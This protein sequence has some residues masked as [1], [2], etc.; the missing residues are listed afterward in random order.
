M[1]D[2]QAVDTMRAMPRTRRL[3]GAGGTTFADA[4]ASFP[5]CCPSR[6]SFLTGQYAHNHGVRDNGPPNGGIAALDQDHTLPVWLSNAGYRTGFVGKYLNGYGKGRNGGE[7]FIPPGWSDW[8][9]APGHG[10]KSPYDYALNENGTLVRYG[11]ERSDY[12]TDVFADLAVDYIARAA[13]DRP[14]FLWVAT[15]APHTDNGLPANAPRNPVPAERDRG[16]FSAVRLPMPASFN[17]A[18][19][20]DKPLFVRKQPP[21]NGR[22]RDEMRRRYVSQLESLLAVDELVARIVAEL[23]ARDELA[24]TVI[25]FTS[26]NGYLRGQHRLDSGKS[27][28]YDASVRVPLIIR[29][30]G[31]PADRVVRSPVANIDLSATIVAAAGLHPDIVIDGVPLR[32]AIT[33]RDARRDVLIEVFERPEGRLTGLRTVRFT[34]AEHDDGTIEL[35]DRRIDPDELENV[36]EKARYGRVRERLAALLVERRDCT[37]VGCR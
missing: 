7:L 26:D 33:G 8:Y 30:P 18:N 21:I 24:S 34:Y 13:G 31:F 1:T 29:G 14:F 19:V 10:K 3:L 11:S 37:G 2:D 25:A 15:S 12:R 20:S 9:A 5:L 27:K 32:H 17:E 35:Y 23:R 6:S 4:L 16:R 36:A 22:Q 28:L